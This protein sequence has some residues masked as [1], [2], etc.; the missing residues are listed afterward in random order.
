MSTYSKGNF[1]P[2]INTNHGIRAPQ[3]LVIDAEG[4]K[5][6]VIPTSEAI[7][8]AKAEGFDLIEING[9]VSPPVCKIGDFGRYKFELQKK[10]KAALK[11]S[12][13]NRVEIKEVCIHPTTGEHDLNT[14]ATNMLR[15]LQE[16][17][18]VKVVVEFRRREMQHQD[19]GMNN[20]NNLLS[21][22]PVNSFVME[23]R[24]SMNGRYL[25][26]LLA[27]PPTKP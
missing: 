7:A 22:M 5:V 1:R 23:E 19:V 21:C 14:K 12:R 18:K 20:L 26:T 27:P 13:E 8:Q 3:V 11:A 2:R 10:E 24:P 25:S 16:G 15:W 6:G 17:D 9:K 4:N